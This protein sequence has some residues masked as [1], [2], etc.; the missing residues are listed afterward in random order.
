MTPAN[1]RNVPAAIGRRVRQRAGNRCGYCL[2]SEMLLGM[3]MEFDHLIPQAAGGTT[4][5]EN[6]WLAC[7]RCNA[8]KGTQTHALDPQ[9]GERVAL[10]NPRQQVWIDHFSWSEDGTE[11]IGKTACG[12]A[13]VTALRMNNVAIVVARRSWVSVGWWPPSG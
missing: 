11:V 2:C 5:E 4:H 6:L 1:R 9:S 10:F 12:R 7:R 3:P 13:T 8:F